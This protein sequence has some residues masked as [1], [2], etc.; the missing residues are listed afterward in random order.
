MPFYP[1]YTPILE[2]QMQEDFRQRVVAVDWPAPPNVRAVVTTRDASLW[3]ESSPHGFNLGTRCGDDTATVASNRVFLRS[4]LAL[5]S[6]PGWLRQ[7]HGTNV[8][9]FDCP[10]PDPPPRA[11]EGDERVARMGG[12]NDVLPRAG[13]GGQRA[14]RTDVFP[15][16]LAG[17]GSPHAVRTG[18]GKIAEGWYEPEADSAVT[19]TP[20]VVLAI[21]TA[22]CLPVFFCADDGS[23]V[24]AAHAGWRG[25]SAGV[26][27]N[28]LA[29]MDTSRGKII[30]WLGPAI[31]ARSY[32]VGDEVRDAFLAR[33]PAAASAFNTTRPGHWLCDLYELARLRLRAAGV[34][35]IFGGDLDTFT[36]ARLHSYRRDGARSGRMASL[37]WISPTSAG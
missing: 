25:L 23:E 16:P 5:P 21:L 13:E 28:T 4:A 19:R 2:R 29:A 18:E 15:L 17:E 9:V 34:T 24:A 22:D 10:H 3:S 35:R 31:A 1:C 7:L 33:D 37:V 6:E 30:T 32:E 36:D 27:E 14:A 12:G 20:G 11:G 8:V 26:L